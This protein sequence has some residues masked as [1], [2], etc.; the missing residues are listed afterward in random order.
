[1]W[2][3]YRP[4]VPA[5]G[6]TRILRPEPLIAARQRVEGI[7]GVLPASANAIAQAA[8]GLPQCDREKPRPRSRG[9]GF[10]L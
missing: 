6:D 5:T 9:G 7:V 2:K 8:V 4:A 3:P 1:M 10:S